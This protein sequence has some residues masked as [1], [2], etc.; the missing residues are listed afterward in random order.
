MEEDLSIVFPRFYEQA[1]VSVGQG[2]EPFELD[3]ETLRAIS[4]AA[5]DLLPPVSKSTPCGSRLEARRYRVIRQGSIIFVRIDESPA[6]CGRMG[7]SMDSG[8]NY[9]I[10]TDGRILRRV[11]D[12][13]LDRASGLEAVDA[14]SQGT[15]A[16]PGTSGVER[17]GDGPSPFLPPQWQDAGVPEGVSP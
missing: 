13:E 7:P 10:S 3:G 17:F 15:P 1:T 5:Q 8:A 9:A 11:I 14:G 12:G 6:Y 16:E 2:S 4:V